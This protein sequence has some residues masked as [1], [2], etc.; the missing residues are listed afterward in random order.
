MTSGGMRAGGCADLRRDV[1]DLTPRAETRRPAR[2]S[3][4]VRADVVGE[5]ELVRREDL[6]AVVGVG[7][8]RG[9]IMRPA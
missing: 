1:E 9:G 5:L 6:D 4:P 3:L 8:V 2:M 7:I